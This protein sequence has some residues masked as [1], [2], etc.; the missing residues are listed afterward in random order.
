MPQRTAPKSG[1]GRGVSW[2]R[3][4]GT[5]C[6]PQGVLRVQTLEPTLAP[7][8]KHDDSCMLLHSYSQCTYVTYI[9]CIESLPLAPALRCLA[10]WSSV[11]FPVRCRLYG[12]AKFQGGKQKQSDSKTFHLTNV[13]KEGTSVVL[14]RIELA[15]SLSLYLSLSLS[16]SHK[17]ACTCA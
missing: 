5:M 16:L 10:P 15:L 1:R 3:Y 4:L 12:V 9:I 17:N 7:M 8:C 6:L 14:E 13:N 11:V 2:F